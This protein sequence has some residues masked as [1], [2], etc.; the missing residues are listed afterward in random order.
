M[1]ICKLRL[2]ACEPEMK[3]IVSITTIDGINLLSVT[4]RFLVARGKGNQIR[5]FLRVRQQ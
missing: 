1:N 3:S 2:C 4:L 5:D